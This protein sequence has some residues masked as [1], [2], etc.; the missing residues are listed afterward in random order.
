MAHRTEF[1][2]V[3]S[4]L[5]VMRA[6]MPWWPERFCSRIPDKTAMAELVRSY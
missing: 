1:L 5:L 2:T 3:P 4:V 6:P